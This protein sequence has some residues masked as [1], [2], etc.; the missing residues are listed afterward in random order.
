MT[1]QKQF[2]EQKN[3]G[4]LRQKDLLL[5]KSIY[6]IG[7]KFQEYRPV[8]YGIL[9]YTTHIIT[10]YAVDMPSLNELEAYTGFLHHQQ[11]FEV[12]MKNRGYGNKNL[13]VMLRAILNAYLN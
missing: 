10:F 9:I 3:E 12:T 11:I 7:L 6:F 4:C 13:I 2:V 8:Q 5:Y 1:S